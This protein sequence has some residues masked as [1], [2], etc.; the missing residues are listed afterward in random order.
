MSLVL[1]ITLSEVKYREWMTFLAVLLTVC[2]GVAFFKL[3]YKL[4]FPD[5]VRWFHVL[6]LIGFMLMIFSLWFR[7]KMFTIEKENAVMEERYNLARSVSHDI[8]T[9]MMVMRFIL[10]KFEQEGLTERE[11]SLLMDSVKEMSGIVDSILPG[12]SKRYENLSF[13]AINPIVENCVAQ[14]KF[15]YKI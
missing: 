7:S 8:M 14:K 9:P 15:L 12:V 13:E 3:N 5:Q 4:N 11:K 6:Y 10:K 2:G 1:I